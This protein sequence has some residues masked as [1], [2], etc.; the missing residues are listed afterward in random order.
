MCS[1]R[2]ERGEAACSNGRSIKG[3]EIEARVLA[4]V[5]DRLLSSELVAVAVDE[6]RRSA[7]REARELTLSRSKL[8]KELTEVKRRA[9]RLVDQ[10]ADGVLT[11]VAVK[12]RLD[13]LET[14]RAEL[15][16]RLPLRLRRL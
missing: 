5:K 14:R 8:E 1:W 2:R 9:E 7:E 12:D 10:V 4:A 15:E 13:L 6:A 16:G 11:G 3:G